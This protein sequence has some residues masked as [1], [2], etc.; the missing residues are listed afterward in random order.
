MKKSR[1]TESQIVKPRPGAAPHVSA[2]S[3]SRLRVSYRLDGELTLS[4]RQVAERIAKSPRA[5]P[6][7][8]ITPC[9]TATA[10]SR[11]HP[12]GEP[13]DCHRRQ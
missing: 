13:E 4:R 2:E 3:H 8:R 1:F 6:V 10:P 7:P 12:P 5:M 9:R 11:P